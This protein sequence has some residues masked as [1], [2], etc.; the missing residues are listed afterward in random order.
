MSLDC[1]QNKKLRQRG[2]QHFPR[3]RFFFHIRF[4]QIWRANP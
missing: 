2:F 3:R 1:L 4:L